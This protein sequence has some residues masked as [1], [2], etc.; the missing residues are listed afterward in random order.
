[1]KLC[2]PIFFGQSQF[3]GSKLGPLLFH[4]MKIKHT[5]VPI[6]G[7]AYVGR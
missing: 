7:L 2:N 4:K 6:V 5:Q 3:R 1:M